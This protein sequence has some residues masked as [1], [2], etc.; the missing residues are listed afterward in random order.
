MEGKQ[1]L[2]RY[3]FED[4]SDILIPECELYVEDQGIST[5]FGDLWQ[6]SMFYCLTE[7][8]AKELFEK[9]TSRISKKYKNGHK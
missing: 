1:S 3:S 9:E 5:G 2:T 8:V 6:W 4:S 7:D